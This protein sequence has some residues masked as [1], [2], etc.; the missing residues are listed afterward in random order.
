MQAEG[1][2]MLTMD[3]SR[4][5]VCAATH[6][7]G[8]DSRMALMPEEL[9]DWR[10]ADKSRASHV[11]GGELLLSSRDVSL[12]VPTSIA[13]AES[14]GRL[15]V[16]HSLDSRNVLRLP[17]VLSEGDFDK[18]RLQ[19]PGSAAEDRS[20][21]YEAAVHL[22]WH[23]DSSDSSEDAV[24]GAGASRR[25]AQA[26]IAKQTPAI[27]C[28]PKGKASG[29]AGSKGVKEVGK[30]AKAAHAGADGDGEGKLSGT[31]TSEEINI[32]FNALSTHGRSFPKIHN[33]LQNTKTRDQVR[34]YYYRVVKKINQV[35]LDSS[36][37]PFSSFFFLFPAFFVFFLILLHPLETSR[38]A[39]CRR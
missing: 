20:G 24:P 23:A 11:S 6:P 19:Q 29:G 26:P 5:S 33:G 34:C 10:G 32:F 25:E 30:G 31:W 3:D 35:S 7:F 36:M 15:F 1:S 4:M 14:R 39:T 21:H 22:H 17:A 18:T 27:K 37:L 38:L 28:G 16:D 8:D 2:S 13:A 12:D 9:A